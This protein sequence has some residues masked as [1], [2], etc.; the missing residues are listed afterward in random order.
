MEPSI[1]KGSWDKEEDALLIQGVRLHGSR[2]VTINFF[3][4]HYWAR[5]CSPP[6][7]FSSFCGF[8][9]SPTSFHYYLWRMPPDIN[10]SDRGAVFCRRAQVP[11]ALVPHFIYGGDAACHHQNPTQSLAIDTHSALDPLLLQANTV[12]VVLAVGQIDLT[13]SFSLHCSKKQGI[14][15]ENR[16]ANRIKPGG[17]QCHK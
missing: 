9:L 4:V 1:N 5:N 15:C 12:V 13:T 14:Q 6:S 2:L 7:L 10:R 16:L 17:P 11:S 3:S 8:S